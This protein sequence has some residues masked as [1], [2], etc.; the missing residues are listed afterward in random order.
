MKKLDARID[1]IEEELGR[2][3]EDRDDRSGRSMEDGLLDEIRLLRHTEDEANRRRSTMTRTCI[4]RTLLDVML[5]LAITALMISC[6]FAPDGQEITAQDLKNSSWL[7]SETMVGGLAVFGIEFDGTGKAGSILT[8]GRNGTKP[9]AFK[10][11][12]NVMTI[13]FP[14]M[15]WDFTTDYESFL[16]IYHDGQ[17]ITFVKSAF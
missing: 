6:A 5:A 8:S 11:E 1:R 13:G 15:T 12:G 16:T 7:C 14:E 17:E 3:L 9:V 4:A 2:I 10:T